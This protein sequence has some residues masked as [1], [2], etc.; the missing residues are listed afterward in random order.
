M[1]IAYLDDKFVPLDR[2][3]VS[4][5]D[6]G[7]LYGDGVFE[8]MRSYRGTVFR[9]E[10]H[11][12][13]LSRALKIIHIDLKLR[14]SK[15]E[16]II[17]N[18][19]DRNKLSACDCGGKDAYIKIITTRGRS[20][21]LLAPPGRTRATFVVYA[22]RYDP[23]PKRVYEEGIK[24]VI[25]K[26]GTNERSVIAGYKTLNYLH[27]ILCR[28]EAVKKGFED[29]VLI[30][31]KGFVSEASSSNIFVVKRKELFTPCLKSGCLAGITRNEVTRIA[32]RILKYKHKESYVK[33][34]DLY[35]ADEVFITNSLAEIMPVVKIDNRAIGSGRPGPVT[36]E[37][38]AL[39]KDSVEEY[40]KKKKI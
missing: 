20:S 40:L 19:L 14:F 11:V 13:R 34:S 30:N 2:A 16:K 10:E 5:L 21:G 29:A 24:T 25:S 39:Y 22:L 35:N 15:I 17:Y 18:W 28:Y 37:V 26:E 23:P 3:K 1:K 4:I 7:F 27:N 8:T 33:I 32:K 38:I 31:T 36:K 9:L 12:G 6:R